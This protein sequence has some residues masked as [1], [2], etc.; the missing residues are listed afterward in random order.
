MQTLIGLVAILAWFS[1]AEP[2]QD[3]VPSFLNGATQTILARGIRPYE[4]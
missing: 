3:S 4:G 2:K 1:G